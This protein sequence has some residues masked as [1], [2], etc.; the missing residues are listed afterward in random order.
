MTTRPATGDPTPPTSDLQV[1][2]EGMTCANCVARVEKA[3]RKVDGVELASVNLA[4]ERAAIR[5]DPR[6]TSAPRL[7]A[8]IRDSG[9]EVTTADLTLAVEGMTCANCVARVERALR[10]VDGVL[11]ANVN[12]ASER[13]TVRY[14]PSAATP[15]QLKAAVRDAGYGVIESGDGRERV[16]AEREARA[17]NLRAQRRQLALAASF[18]LPVVVLAMV[19][20]VFPGA[21]QWLAQRVNVRYLYL[22]EFALASVV[23]FGPG[24]RFYRAGW[25]ST[26]HGAPDMNALVVMGSSAAYGYSVV[27]T[28]VPQLLPA[29]TA[30]VYF[31]ASS[32][33]ITLIL[34]GKYLEAVA[35]GRT[36]EAMKKL[37]D[38]QARSARVVR[39]DSELELPIDE[40][41]PGDV[42]LVRPG[43]RIPVDGAVLEGSS[44]VDES[45]ITG[46]PMPAAKRPGDDVVGGTVNRTG[47]FRFRAEKVGSDTVLAR[48]I[49]LV[50]DAQGSKPRIQSLADRVV[51]IFVPVVLALATL[52][53]L[54]WLAFGP[55]PALTFALVN[56]VAVLVIA[57]PCAMGL[58]TPTSIMVG[59]GKAAE[60]GL[61]FRNGDALQ[62]LQE[63]RIIAIDKTGTLTM[64]RPEV[65]DV[66]P[67]EPGGEERLLS[68]AAAV[69]ALSEHPIAEAVVRAVHERGLAM[70]R[71]DG[72]DAVPGFGVSASVDGERVHIGAAR[73][74]L[75]QGIDPAALAA[76]A[77]RL[78]VAGRTP[79]FVAIDGR[80]A[81]LLSVAD[82]IKPS[83]PAALAALHELGLRVAMITG[84][85]A[86]TAHA[87][88]RELGI[89]EVR[90]EVLPEGKADAVAALQAGGRRVA[91]VG[92]GINDAPALARADIG[93]AIGTGTDIAIE[94]GDVILMSGDLRG[95]PDA[96]ALSRATLTNIRQNLFWAF[97]YNIVL[98]PVAAGALY[99]ALG[100]LLNPMLAAAAMGTSSVFVLSN[101]LRLRAFR[102]PR[103]G[104]GRRDAGRVAPV[105]A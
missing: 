37:L 66:V 52:T 23:Q 55:Q 49:R 38:L 59:A 74:L 39:G 45:M 17:R 77:E 88:A 28:F 67:L 53:F 34:L 30:H 26:R 87:I 10:K 54:G 15:G 85:D 47:A 79:L 35:K 93:V 4:T 3:L 43:E 76:D 5:F 50:E 64:G 20:M 78:A 81:G 98:I 33:I 12:L 91:F 84:D 19:P 36:G 80:L 32:A 13:A 24:R 100:I 8:A 61:L 72:F 89:D 62:G 60:M 16:D 41:L 105:P 83:T 94:A 46:E 92:D 48:I 102:P 7:L 103:A 99:P 27:A 14:L 11:D 71:A 58:A 56:A 2:V 69:E 40:V 82:P 90:A 65:T 95:I 63:A 75:A 97:V 70:G 6:A 96:I 9:Y 57:C 44:Y 25:A 101:A 104:A 68:T 86:R 73:H 29:G 31:E 22:V 1:A 18:A 21:E 42:V 51:S